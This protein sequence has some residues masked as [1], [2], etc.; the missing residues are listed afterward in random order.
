MADVHYWLLAHAGLP[1]KPTQYFAFCTNG[2]G[3]PTNP[4]KAMRWMELEGAQQFAE[5]LLGNWTP[6]LM[7]F[8]GAALCGGIGQNPNST[9]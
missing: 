9:L 8:D 4:A 1:F 3:L 2:D 6:V 5:K 7:K